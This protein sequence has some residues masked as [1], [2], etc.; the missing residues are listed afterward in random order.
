[1]HHTKMER[2]SCVERLW[3]A[4]AL[5]QLWCVSLG[6]QAESEQEQAWAER[7]PGADLPP[8]HRARR[9]RTRPAGQHAPRRLSCV[10]RGH[11]LL[12]AMQFQ[13]HMLSMGTLRLDAWPEMMLPPQ[14]PGTKKKNATKTAKQKERR[15]YAR[16]RAEERVSA[17]QEKNR[18]VAGGQGGA[19]R[20]LLPNDTQTGN[21]SAL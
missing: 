1:M 10:L 19:Y 8:T 4:L 2:A 15:K 9:S 17:Q 18:Y 20:T 7:E 21:S 14:K 12:L 11:L 5:A 6:C 3:L 13:S 16:R